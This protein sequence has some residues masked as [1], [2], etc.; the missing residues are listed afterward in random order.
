MLPYK[1]IHQINFRLN[2]H[3]SLK[4]GEEELQRVKVESTKSETSRQS[5]KDDEVEVTS[6]PGT[7]FTT[8]LQGRYNGKR[9]IAETL[10]NVY[11]ICLRATS[12]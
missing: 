7:I 4:I 1:P 9:Q 3:Q 6:T 12:F 11:Y 2:D 5:I 10:R 8:D